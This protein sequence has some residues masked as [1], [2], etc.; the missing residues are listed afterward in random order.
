[1]ILGVSGT[2][3]AVIPLGARLGHPI[4]R[5][6][7]EE[8]GVD[9]QTSE[10]VIAR[11]ADGYVPWQENSFPDSWPTWWPDASRIVWICTAPTASSTRRARR[12]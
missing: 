11:I 7:L 6:A 10:D 9:A 4:W 8:S 2:L 12:R 1:M 5:K 3:P